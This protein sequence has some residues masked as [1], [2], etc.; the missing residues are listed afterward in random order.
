MAD[1]AMLRELGITSVGKRIQFLKAVRTL[2]AEHGIPSEGEDSADELV[3]RLEELY[4]EERDRNVAKSRRA[5]TQ[6]LLALEDAILRRDENIRVLN[7]RLAK[8]ALELDAVR[9]ELA[10]RPRAGMGSA[11]AGTPTSP[12]APSPVEDGKEREVIKVFADS[13]LQRD[14]QKYKTI[15]ITPDDSVQVV[16]QTV[17]RKYAIKEANP[18][19]YSLTLVSGPNKQERVM[20]FPP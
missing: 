8:L 17:L 9:A 14:N 5:T 15:N 3:N 2:R 10:D 19:D 16:L 11:L 12:A 7:E 1:H 6:E 4:G 13:F 18:R 20:A